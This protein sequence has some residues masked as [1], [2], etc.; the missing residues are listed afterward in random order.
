[1]FA[2]SSFFPITG[3][4]Y[5]EH[6]GRRIHYLG[7]PRGCLGIGDPDPRGG[8][9]RPSVALAVPTSCVLPLSC[10]PPFTRGELRRGPLESCGFA[11][12]RGRGT[13]FIQ[14]PSFLLPPAGRWPRGCGEGGAREGARGPGGGLSF[15]AALSLNPPWAVVAQIPVVNSCSDLFEEF[16]GRGGLRGRSRAHPR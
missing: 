13:V 14:R 12:P 15:R 3:A 16:L 9:V 1:V 6:L 10:R 8:R 5:T 4:Y 2:P 11:G 7:M